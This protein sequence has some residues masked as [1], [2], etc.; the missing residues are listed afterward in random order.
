MLDSLPLEL[1]GLVEPFAEVRGF[2]DCWRVI[3]MFGSAASII[4]RNSLKSTTC[5]T[6]NLNLVVAASTHNIWFRR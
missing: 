4:S 2:R 6:K 5:T 1:R 3:R